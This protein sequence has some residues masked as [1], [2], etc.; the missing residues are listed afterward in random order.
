MLNIDL[1]MLIINRMSSWERASHHAAPFK[2][3]LQTRGHQTLKRGSAPYGQEQ[4]E[5][6]PGEDD[7]NEAHDSIPPPC[8]DVHLIPSD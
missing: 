8:L 3:S 7:E 4:V 5:W 1:E 2:F 6:S